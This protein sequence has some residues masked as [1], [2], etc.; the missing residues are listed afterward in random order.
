MNLLPKVVLV[1]LL[2]VHQVKVHGVTVDQ[3]EVEVVQHHYQ[4]KLLL[5]LVLAVVEA[6]AETAVRIVASSPPVVTAVRV[7]RVLLGSL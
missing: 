1:L 5:Q 3:V 6:V 2:V 4:L 7:R